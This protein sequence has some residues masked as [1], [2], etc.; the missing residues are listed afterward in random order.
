MTLRIRDK[1]CFLLRAGHIGRDVDK[2][3]NYEDTKTDV[4]YFK[5]AEGITYLTDMV[6]KTD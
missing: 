5:E 2:G 1:H 6:L 4:H 3:G